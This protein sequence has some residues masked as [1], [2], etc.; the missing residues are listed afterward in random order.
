MA[1]LP[2]LTHNA[3]WSDGATKHARYMVKNDYIGHDE[4]PSNPWFTPEGREAA[5]SGNVLVSSD[6]NMRAEEAID[7]WMQGPF[8]AVGILDPALH[9]TGF[10]VYREAIGVRHFGATL[11]V[12]RGR[13]AVP[14]T[15]SFPVMW[16]GDGATVHLTTFLGNEFP[17]PL[18]SCP[19]YTAPTGLPI[20]VQLGTGTLTPQVTAHAFRQGTVELPHCLF[21]ETT[22]VHPDPTFQSWGRA[23]LNARDAVI[24]IPRDPLEPGAHYTVSLTVNGQFFT[25]TFSVAET[26]SRFEPNSTMVLR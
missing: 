15:V 16:P 10:G 23:I 18:S 6:I 25:W 3:Q 13:S 26:P 19:G 22:Y 7:M 1:H 9:A 2:P 12:L 5:R 20:I 24:L 11:D 17:D 21:D 4:D 8:H 14:A